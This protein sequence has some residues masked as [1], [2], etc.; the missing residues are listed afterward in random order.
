VESF[1]AWFTHKGVYVLPD[2]TPVIALWTELG[3]R[4]RWWFVA[5]QGQLPGR[6]GE[7]QLV[8]YENGSIYNYTPE[9]DGAYP[10]VYI[11]YPSDLCVEDINPAES[12]LRQDTG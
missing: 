1:Q 4:P 9:M 7:L 12:G 3:D 5:Q 6:W 10:A 11:P 2:G 8:V